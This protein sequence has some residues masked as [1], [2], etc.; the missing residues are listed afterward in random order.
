VPKDEV[1]PLTDRADLMDDD[2]LIEDDVAR[3]ASVVPEMRPWRV[4]IVDDEPDVHAVTRF[5]LRNVSFKGRSLELL[6]AYSGAE[7]Y[8]VLAR[9]PD[10]ALVFLDVVMETEQAGL[11]LAQDIR[12][13]LGNHLVRIVLRTGQPGQAPEEA[14]I[15][16][17]DI[18]DYKAKS[19]LTAQKMFTTVIASLRAYDG[20]LMIERNRLGLSKILEGSTNLYEIKSLREFASGVLHQIGAI[21]DVGADGV[22]CVLSDAR[23]GQA[24]Q[25]TV[26]AATGNY[27]SLGELGTLPDDHEWSELIAKAFAEQKSQ[28]HPAVDVLFVHTKQ[29]HQFAVVVTPPWP[30]SELQ[31]N[32]LAVFCD[33]ISA[34]FDNLH[35]YGELRQAQEATVVALADLA[36]SRDADTG[37]H[38]MRVCRLTQAIAE[39][40]LARGQHSEELT[41]DFMAMVGL[42]GILHDVGKVATPDHVLLKP[43]SHTAD[44]RR[45]MEHHATVGERVLARAAGML[46]GSS[47]LSYGAQIAG[48]HHEHMD[49]NGYPRRAKGLEI[50]LAARIVAVVDVFDALL[51]RRSYKQP[52]PM[53]EVRQYVLGRRGTQF[54]PD[55]VDAL[56]SFIDTQQPDWLVGDG[57]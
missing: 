8:E 9:E 16:D 42:A 1:N 31:R 20:L 15:V 57:Q 33:R 50:P 7:G 48:G 43:G 22:L 34:A 39:E 25:S 41:P 46:H 32:L 37:G 18:N 24:F 3:P 36:E 30:L 6:S 54:D 27:A 53:E 38:V 10:I 26:I 55:V 29:G 52:W 28:Y 21:L 17:Y 23:P 12:G 40:L 51:H 35:L 14:V 11:V 5:A 47:Y 49:G 56:F 13:K 19:E 4:L 2:F 45:V 44:E